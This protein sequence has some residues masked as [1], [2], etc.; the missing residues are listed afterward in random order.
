MKFRKIE[1]RPTNFNKWEVCV[2]K[3]DETERNGTDNGPHSLGF[4]YCP[5][6]KPIEQ[7]FI[8]LK[9]LLIKNHEEELH[10]LTLSLESLKQATLDE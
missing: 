2:S 5:K 1:I 7:G 3:L 9:Q 10:R 4:Y 8:E 6:T